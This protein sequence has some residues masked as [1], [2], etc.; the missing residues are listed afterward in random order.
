[1]DSLSFNIKVPLI[2]KAASNV[3]E[4]ISHIKLND[5]I[6]FDKSKFDI[7]EIIKNLENNNVYKKIEAMK[8]IL[9]AHILKKNVSSLFFDVLKNISIDNLTLKKLIYNYLILYAEGNNDL[10]MLSVNSFK[11][12]LNNNDYQIRSSALKA[13]SCIKSIDMINILMES[14]KKLSKDKSPYVRKTCADV[15]PSIYNIDKDQFIFLRKILIDLINDREVSVVSSAIMSFNCICIYDYSEENEEDICNEET[16]EHYYKE[17]ENYPTNENHQKNKNYTDKIDNESSHESNKNL[18]EQ[19]PNNN[20]NNLCTNKIESIHIDSQKKNEN[21]NTYSNIKRRDF[22]NNLNIFNSLSFLHPCYY[23]LCQY[24]LYMH[25]FHQTYLIDLLLRYCRTFYKDPLKND[26]LKLK[27]NNLFNENSFCTEN[28]IKKKKKKYQDSDSEIRSND[29]SYLNNN[30]T[31]EEFKKYDIDIEIFIDKL[32]ILLTSSSYSV[33]IMSISSLYHLTKLTYKDNIIQAIINSLL[34]SSMEK[35]DEIYEIF[36]RSVKPIIVALKKEFSFYLSFFYINCIDSG[37]KKSLKIDILTALKSSDNKM[38]ILDEFLHALYL[39]NNSENI[40]KK[41]FS[42][43]TAIALTNADCLSKVMKYIMIMLN[44]NIKLYSDESILALR[45]LLQQ[46][47]DNQIGKI[48][49]FLSKILLKIQ[50]NQVKISVIWTLAN[51]Q[52]FLDYLL[53]F[54]ISRLLVKSFENSSDVIKIQIIHFVFKIWLYQY[55]RFFLSMDI[56]S[57]MLDEK[58]SKKKCEIKNNNFIQSNYPDNRDLEKKV[59]PPYLCDKEQITFDEKNEAYN[60]YESN[61]NENNESN[62]SESNSDL[63][64]MNKN[65]KTFSDNLSKSKFKEDFMNFEILC[66]KAFLL[67]IKDENF[68]IQDTS[69]FYIN[70]MLIIKEQYLQ[71]KLKPNIFERDFFNEKIDKYSLSLCYLKFTFLYSGKLIVSNSLNINLKNH[72]LKNGIFLQPDCEERLDNFNKNEAQIVYQLNTVSNILN[73]KIS[74]YVDLPEFAENDLPK[75][76]HFNNNEKKKYITSFSSKDIKFNNN[77]DNPISLQTFSNI[78]D[79]YKEENL[80]VEKQKESTKLTSKTLLIN[81]GT[82]IQGEDEESDEEN[83][84]CHEKFENYNLNIKSDKT[85]VKEI[86]DIEQFFFND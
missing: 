27:K 60:D 1:M 51:Y 37:I 26:K 42:H 63:N 59:N 78:D 21:K 79:F 41:L 28:D 77:F 39:P 14:L 31:Y 67:G 24:L 45:Q 43:I 66:K 74:S 48:V 50:S 20:Y 32:L 68:D 7:N 80:N 70:I 9:I 54:D 10:T 44:S 11:K 52:R 62:K 71:K 82:K 81:K 2:E 8:H 57:F 46:S 16:N 34:R 19:I 22:N 5:G 13:M 29:P 17:D 3:K 35:N 72:P 64:D 47:D 38:V 25:P 65:Q 69:K 53:L 56:D 84:N 58:I 83:E 75:T 18:H 40:I 86:E 85:T 76:E 30:D 15:I 33:I 23:K 73:K 4:I 61:I 55:A 49:F 6:Y 12:D 36:L